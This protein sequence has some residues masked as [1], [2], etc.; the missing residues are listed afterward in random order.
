MPSS[1]RRLF[2]LIFA[3]AL[4]QAAL[5]ELRSALGMRRHGRL[6]DR[7][8]ALFGSAGIPAPDGSR[9][10]LELWRDE[11]AGPDENPWYIVLDGP[12]G[13]RLT[14]EQLAHLRARPEEAARSVGLRLAESRVFKVDP[15]VDYQTEWRNENWLRT[16][17]WD[18]PAQTLDELW[19][20]VGATSASVEGR[21][22]ELARFMTSP[23]WEAA[24]TGLRAEADNFLRDGDGEL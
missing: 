13:V 9:F 18:L 21:R 15:P 20:V 3:G 1:S 24:P 17:R 5:D 19:T 4:D 6:T 10:D 12:T 16:I 7:E 8:D 11:D 22:A 2:M 14:T 23:A